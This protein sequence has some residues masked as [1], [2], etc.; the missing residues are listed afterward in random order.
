MCMLLL[1]AG[2][3]RKQ[4]PLIIQT[5]FDRSYREKGSV[6]SLILHVP[7]SFLILDT[8]RYSSPLHLFHRR[9]LVA[10]QHGQMKRFDR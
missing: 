10:M 8:S 5:V 1:V 3:P 6:A 7:A 2:R 9:Q 4:G